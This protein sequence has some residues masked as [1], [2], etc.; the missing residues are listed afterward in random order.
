MNTENDKKTDC[1]PRVGIQ[2]GIILWIA[3]HL[4]DNLR[5]VSVFQQV[6]NIS[7]WLWNRNYKK[8]FPK[9]TT[10]EREQY[11]KEHRPF[12]TSFLFPEVWVILNITLAIIGCIVVGKEAQEWICWILCVY[13][14]LRTF[15]LFVYQINVLL[16]DPIKFG[17]TK[18]RIKSSTRT[19][20]LLICNI[21]EYIL[22]FSVV[23]LFMYRGNVSNVD[24]LHVVLESVSTLANITSPE[25]FSRIDLIFVAYIESVIGIFINIVCLAR[26]ISL[27][28]PIQSLDEN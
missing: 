28:P 18:Y 23:Y 14:I 26:F 17:R 9:A 27:L 19:V 13:G 22:W 15:E 24:S 8:K 1:M 7:Q 21:F 3:F 10:E 5:Q 4:F 12:T 25:D 6:R 11:W 16:F 20:L 2:D